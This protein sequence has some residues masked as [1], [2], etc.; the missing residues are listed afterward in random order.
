MEKASTASFKKSET[1]RWPNVALATIPRLWFGPVIDSGVP[2][3]PVD[4]LR[5]KAEMWSV[6][7]A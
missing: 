5:V 6:L 3:A 2:S 7:V 1:Y 4:G